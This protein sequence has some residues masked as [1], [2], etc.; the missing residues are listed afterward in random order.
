M[1][2][3]A[4]LFGSVRLKT[5]PLTQGKGIIILFGDVFGLRSHWDLPL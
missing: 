2:K 4:L 1:S 5:N 3:L